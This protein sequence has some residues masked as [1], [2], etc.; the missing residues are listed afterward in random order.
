MKLNQRDKDEIVKQVL[1][2]VREMLTI[3]VTLEKTG[4]DANGCK[5]SCPE[6][7]TEKWF[8]PAVFPQILKYYEGSNRGLQEV[9]GKLKDKVGF[10]DA[11]I[12]ETM[13]M[14]EH[15]HEKF[16]RALLAVNNILVSLKE[17]LKLIA[18]EKNEK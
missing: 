4:L 7:K 17:P 2:G 18:G 11:R 10:M 5:T 15:H 8:I 16:G 6:T 13:N 9:T 1:D 14:I 12:E 3:E